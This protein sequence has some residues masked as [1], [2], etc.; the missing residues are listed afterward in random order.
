MIDY[1]KRWN[2]L[3]PNKQALLALR[4]GKR[5]E[6]SSFMRLEPTE[7]KLVAYVVPAPDTS[8]AA[9][10]LR[11]FLKGRLPDYM[12]PDA[13]VLLEELPL[14]PNGKIDRKALSAPVRSRQPDDNFVAPRT[15]LEEEL[16]QIWITVL[17][18]ERVGINDDF[19]EVGGHSLL[20]TQL[21]SR[22]R[23]A[24]QVELPLRSIFETPTLAGLATTIVRHQM[25]LT[26]GE[27]LAELLAELEQ[28]TGE[29]AGRG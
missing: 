5:K 25:E 24:F 17:K 27:D 4:V 19:F 1:A 22:V 9:N 21:I 12:L 29:A 28:Q 11:S 3:S 20:A 2:D 16:A 26:D 13:F 10:Q 8:L 7:K 6:L 14:S 18:V 15:S 23:E